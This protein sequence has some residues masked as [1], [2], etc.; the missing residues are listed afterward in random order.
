M[1]VIVLVAY[2]LL[3]GKLR[4]A[5]EVDRADQHAEACAQELKLYRERL[6]P[7]LEKQQGI[8]EPLQGDMA[9]FKKTLEARAQNVE[10]PR[11][12]RHHG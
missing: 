9:E 5:R 7:I 1:A 4:F 6:L 8:L 2:G 10:R 3:S 11:D 12:D